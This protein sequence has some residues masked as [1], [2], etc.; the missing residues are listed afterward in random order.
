[1][2]TH[3]VVLFTTTYR[4]KPG[5]WGPRLQRGSRKGSGKGT[6][7]RAA[8]AEGWQF[9]YNIASTTP[10]RRPWSKLCGNGL[11]TPRTIQ[12]GKFLEDT[13]AAVFTQKQQIGTGQADFCENGPEIYNLSR[14]GSIM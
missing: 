4:G 3:S 14:G 9:F 12:V 6:R 10:P 1:M 11:P 8:G 5:Q 2:R 7:R 13:L